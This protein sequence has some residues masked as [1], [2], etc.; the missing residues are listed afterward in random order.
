MAEAAKMGDLELMK[1]MKKSL[2]SEAKAQELPDSL[3]G[4][5]TRTEIVNKFKECYE[6]L[7]D[8][9]SSES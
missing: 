3:E 8:S 9:A 7:Y 5:Y 1:A 4:A 6:K 2:I